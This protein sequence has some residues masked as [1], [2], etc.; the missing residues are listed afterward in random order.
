MF[1]PKD[2]S[3][4]NFFDHIRYNSCLWKTVTWIPLRWCWGCAFTCFYLFSFSSYLHFV[5]YITK[6]ILKLTTLWL[7][8]PKQCE[9]LHHRWFILLFTCA[10][11]L[12]IKIRENNRLLVYLITFS[13]MLTSK[14]FNPQSME[15]YL[16]TKFL[17]LIW[18]NDKK[19]AKILAGIEF[20]CSFSLTIPISRQCVYHS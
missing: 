8:R 11:K 15:I 4:W 12:T 10:R 14:Q 1:R 5:N 9:I 6:V 3:Y 7:L 2:E 16:C 17:I 13:L 18:L 19:A 20:V